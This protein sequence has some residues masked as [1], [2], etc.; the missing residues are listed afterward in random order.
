MDRRD[1]VSPHSAT[2]AAVAELDHVFFDP[3]DETTVDTYFAKL[4]H[5]HRNALVMLCGQDAIDQGRLA[6]P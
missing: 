3:N 5:N 1:Q 6:T 2:E 4:I